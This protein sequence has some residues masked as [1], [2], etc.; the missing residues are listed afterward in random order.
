MTT[1]ANDAEERASFWRRAR[2][3]GL[4]SVFGG[5]L[6]ASH[7][8]WTHLLD[9]ADYGRF[10]NLQ[11]LY[12]FLA[13]GLTL[14]PQPFILAHL[15]AWPKER[16]ARALGGLVPLSLTLGALA[17]GL[18]Y[19]APASWLALLG[20]GIPRWAVAGIALAA[21]VSVGRLVAQGVHEARGEA[22]RSSLWTEVGDGLR[23]LIALPVFFALAWTWEA[24][25]VGLVVAQAGAGLL[26]LHLL[27]RAGWLAWPRRGPSMPTGGGAGDSPS[28]ELKGALSFMVPTMLMGVTYVAYDSA[29]RLFV[30]AFH[31]LEAAGSYDVAYR[32]ALLGQ[33]VNIVMRRSFSPVYYAAHARGDH[34]RALAVLRRTSLQTFAA[35]M[36]LAILVPAFLYVVPVLGE[37][38]EGAVWI[39]PIVAVGVGLFGVQGFWQAALLA[40]GKPRVVLGVTVFGALVNVAANAALVPSLAG[41]G[42][43]LGTLICFA[44]MM[45]LMVVMAR[46]A[47]RSDG[48]V[49]AP[50]DDV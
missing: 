20:D 12:A 8:V 38:Y 48:V 26:A 15:H 49:R 40:R 7:V 22:G 35:S 36:G 23:P 30:T 46:R 21:A 24:R 34:A 44:A 14:T 31:G 17:A 37:G 32:I 16:L 50:R 5:L 10:A 3:Y 33:T 2:I 27:A 9:P 41:V 19:A 4:A 11:V 42:A 28:K 13:A 43:A 25:W 47:M 6:H 29:D 18:A 1:D 45:A 39:V